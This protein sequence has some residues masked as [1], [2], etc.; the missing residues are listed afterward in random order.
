MKRF[1][2]NSCVGE[3]V[4]YSLQCSN[5]MQGGL[6]DRIQM[7]MGRCLFA[8]TASIDSVEAQMARRVLFTARGNK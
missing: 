6:S 2:H 7:T 5:R 1:T 3:D 8:E 4:M